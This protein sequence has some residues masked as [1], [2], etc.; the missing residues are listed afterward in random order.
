MLRSLIT[1]SLVF[2][3]TYAMFAQQQ[4][5]EINQLDKNGRK[6]GLWKKYDEGGMII[7]EGNFEA[8]LPVGVFK[9]FYPDGKTKAIMNFSDKGRKSES[10]TY[11]YSGKVMSHGYYYQQ[12]KDSLWM[13]YDMQGTLLKEEFYRQ[14]IKYGSWK[15]YYPEGQVAEETN[16]ENDLQHGPWIQYYPDGQIKMQGAYDNNEKQGPISYFYPSGRSRIT[17]QYDQSYRM[18]TWYY[19]NDSSQVT[20]IEY[21]EEGKLVKEE[22]FDNPE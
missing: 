6:T 15:T 12:K 21:Y 14:E 7:Y 17:G 5:Q 11:H 2:L 4:S 19:M 1:F 9:Y 10:T 13:F 16:W 3:L 22:T 8:D 20:R 18:G